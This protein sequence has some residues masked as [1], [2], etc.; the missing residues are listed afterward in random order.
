MDQKN[1]PTDA[2]EQELARGRDAISDAREAYSSVLTTETVP[3]PFVEAI[4]GLEE[5]FDNLDQT[6][7][8]DWEDV[9]IA[10]QTA[11]KAVLLADVFNALEHRHRAEIEAELTRLKL[12]SDGLENL[13]SEV[14]LPESVRS[15]LDRVNR[16]FRMLR[17]LADDDRYGQIM[18]NERI[19]PDTVDAD[20]RRL[21][22]ECSESVPDD[23]QARQYISIADQLLESIHEALRELDDE[24]K[25]KTAFASELRATKD[26]IE[27]AKA[28]LDT[29]KVSK[30]TRLARAGLEGVFMIH[31]Q[32]STAGANA[33]L[34][35]RLVTLL[36]NADGGINKGLAADKRGD[37]DELLDVLSSLIGAQVERSFIDRFEQLLR[38]HDG[39]VAQTVE[40]TDF[41]AETVFEHLEQLYQKPGVSDIEV[42]FER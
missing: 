7:N 1:S 25:E 4:G 12:Y 19:S 28:K 40:A 35:E 10:K 3:D 34:A 32:V 11:Q 14:N 16:Q 36:D 26:R 30:A 23:Q 18:S 33:K 17:K 37:V 39:S 20:L 21:E 29:D 13:L 22:A 6:L 9:K 8:V 41:D 38:E 2:F 31:Q 27:D 42:I 24:N 5:Q 15:E